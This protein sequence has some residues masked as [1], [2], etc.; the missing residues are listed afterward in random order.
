MIPNHLR[1]FV[2]VTDTRSF[3]KAAEKL[4]VS[5]STIS[6]AVSSLEA[7]LHAEL[8]V[9]GA[10]QFTLTPSGKCLYA[11]AVD[12]L[13]Y[14]AQ[15]EKELHAR[16]ENTDSKLRLSIP[17]TAGGIYFYALIS[18]F[19]QMY[20]QIHLMLNDATSRYIP[21]MLLSN[22]IDLGIVI[23]P[24][25]DKRFV[26]KVAFQSEAVLVVPKEHPFASMES[27]TA[28][29]LQ[30]EKFLQ[31]TRNFQYY[32]VF[33]DYCNMA[34][35]E[36]NIT[37]ATDQW[38]ML[39][40]LVADGQGITILPRPLVEKH[41]PKR[42]QF[43]HLTEPEFPWALDVIYPVNAIVTRPMMKFLELLDY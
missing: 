9:R 20:P 13:N 23:E 40:E 37:F 14:Y 10:G 24:F 7:E 17:P 1:Y 19:K 38:D 27:V 30:N 39:L 25:E 16:L 22:T 31:V 36:P 33:V 32:Q 5:Q 21:D 12:V 42:A 35:F 29:L 43:L 26:K 41:L 34:G 18:D 11:F 15:R 3:T 28:G 8:H 4:F 2:E 6:K